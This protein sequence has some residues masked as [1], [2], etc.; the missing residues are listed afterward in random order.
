M[1]ERRS[2]ESVFAALRVLFPQDSRVLDLDL[3]ALCDWSDFASG[4]WQE[5]EVAVPLLGVMCVGGASFVHT[6]EFSRFFP[7]ECFSSFNVAKAW[8]LPLYRNTPSNNALL[9]EISAAIG[10]PS[11]K[12]S[13]RE[14]CGLL[15]IFSGF[16]ESS[17]DASVAVKLLP[18]FSPSLPLSLARNMFDIYQRH[19]F[20]S[21]CSAGIT[22]DA[23]SQSCSKTVGFECRRT[24]DDSKPLLFLALKK[25][26]DPAVSVTRQP[27]LKRAAKLILACSQTMPLDVFRCGLVDIML[28]LPPSTDSDDCMLRAIGE[29]TARLCVLPVA[30][31]NPC[32]V[33]DST[34]PNNWPDILDARIAEIHRVGHRTFDGMVRAFLCGRRQF[35]QSCGDL[36]PGIVDALH[37]ALSDHF[38]AHYASSQVYHD[39]ILHCCATGFRRA[40]HPL[41]Q[42]SSPAV[43]ATPAPVVSSRPQAP[44]HAVASDALVDLKDGDYSCRDI[45]CVIRCL[46]SML[47]SGEFNYRHIRPCVSFLSAFALLQSSTPELESLYVGFGAILDCVIPAIDPRNDQFLHICILPRHICEVVTMFKGLELSRVCAEGETVENAVSSLGWCEVCIGSEDNYCSGTRLPLLHS[48]VLDAF[49]RRP[50]SLTV[51]ELV[52]ETKFQFQTVHRCLCALVDMGFLRSEA[53]SASGEAVFSVASMPPVVP[54][55]NKVVLIEQQ[56]QCPSPLC[57]DTVAAYIEICSIILNAIIRYS[58]S[59]N[60]ALVPE[61]RLIATVS[62]SECVPPADVYSAIYYMVARN[63]IKRVSTGI[64]TFI[65]LARDTGPDGLS[66]CSAADSAAAAAD[67]PFLKFGESRSIHKVVVFAIS[68]TDRLHVTS[69]DPFP[70]PLFQRCMI[71][72]NPSCCVELGHKGRAEDLLTRTINQLC[73][74]SNLSFLIAA[75]ELM[76]SHGYPERVLIKYIDSALHA[77]MFSEDVLC[78]TEVAGATAF[79]DGVPRCHVCTDMNDLIQLPCKH[80]IC[81]EC[82]ADRFLN[83]KSQ[84]A[85]GAL[86][87]DQTPVSHVTDDDS[88]LADYFSCPFCK[89]PL[90]AQFWS[91]FPNR[92]TRSQNKKPNVERVTLELVHRKIVLNSLRVLRMDALSTIAR[93]RGRKDV[94]SLNSQHN[95]C[96]VVSLNNSHPVMCQGRFFDRITDIKNA[97]SS[98]GISSIEYQWKELEK[99]ISEQSQGA[100]ASDA[101]AVDELKPHFVSDSERPSSEAGRLMDFRMCPVC[102]FGNIVNTACANMGTHHGEQ[103]SINGTTT[104]VLSSSQPAAR[105]CSAHFCCSMHPVWVFLRDVER[106]A[107]E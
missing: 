45:V 106:L 32:D 21:T 30:P 77:S 97:D 26:L 20:T 9:S 105:P 2:A 98:H 63:I 4:V 48:A 34:A 107:K 37:A 69:R 66:A 39:C 25:F 80:C 100:V 75:K 104:R 50:G 38:R 93:C 41:Q 59:S 62:R 23:E 44:S 14:N 73:T 15:V 84:H 74:C 61:A 31:S 43:C 57:V 58:N 28:K 29:V 1:H 92:L 18:V 11:A 51:S 19:F 24:D 5:I 53:V 89:S 76:N 22:G 96:Y 10:I 7:C 83:E 65:G 99:K 17:M 88:H 8:V 42:H 78:K 6:E 81:E 64:A 101:A 54:S 60:S 82:F 103:N 47:L 94:D 71:S 67:T 72:L 70:Q 3:A 33:L 27:L 79:G 35:V 13:A 91:E 95:W 102:F 52:A 40:Q 46:I 56:Q 68:D 86:P 12:L 36:H 85:F 16:T 55:T 87:G 90:G 49:S